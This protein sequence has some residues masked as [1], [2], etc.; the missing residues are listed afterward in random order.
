M[1]IQKGIS[2][3]GRDAIN[4]SRHVCTCVFVFLV[5]VH[6]FT[7][8]HPQTCQMH[9][10]TH[11]HIHIYTHQTYLHTHVHRFTA[12]AAGVF[13]GA[14]EA[15]VTTPFQTIKVRLQVCMRMYM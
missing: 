12:G 1:N 2:N 15:F 9:I 3:I 14:P 13:A 8:S 7:C 5:Y 11:I 6:A 10:D 4:A